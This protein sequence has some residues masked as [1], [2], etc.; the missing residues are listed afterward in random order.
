MLAR[1]VSQAQLSDKCAMPTPIKAI[2]AKIG[3]GIALGYEANTVS[4]RYA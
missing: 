1:C 2:P 4:E 3:V